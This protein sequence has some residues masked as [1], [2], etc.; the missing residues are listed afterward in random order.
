[1]KEKVKEIRAYQTREKASLG[2]PPE[3]A[4]TR[5]QKEER[6]LALGCPAAVLQQLRTRQA[7]ARTANVDAAN[8]AKAAQIA[9]QIAD[10]KS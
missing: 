1:M 2:A 3:F 9:R 7:G 6:L 10:E 8:R 4:M 5:A